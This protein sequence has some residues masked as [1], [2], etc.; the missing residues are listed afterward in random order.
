MVWELEMLAELR[1]LCQENYDSFW[2]SKPSLNRLESFLEDLKQHM[3][4]MD[5]RLTDTKNRVNATE[6]RGIWQER[7]LSY[8]LQG[9]A[10]LTAKESR[11]SISGLLEYLKA[12]KGRIQ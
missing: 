6:H 9:E 11:L 3:K 7:V 1:K 4:G 10:N 2:D 12:L 8:L 5:K